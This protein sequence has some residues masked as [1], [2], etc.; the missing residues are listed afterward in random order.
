MKKIVNSA[1]TLMEVMVVLIVLGI[2]AGFAV[3]SYQKS[4]FLSH[5]KTAVLNLRMLREAIQLDRATNG[6]YWNTGGPEDDLSVINQKLGTHIF[7]QSTETYECT[8][9]PAADP[10]TPTYTC[11]VRFNNSPLNKNGNWGVTFDQLTLNGERC[12]CW[13]GACPSCLNG[14]GG[15]CTY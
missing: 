11:G 12:Y 6:E 9:N 4:L 15:G 3:T 2:I 14:A 10:S 5:E 13:Y 8:V 1:F 7:L